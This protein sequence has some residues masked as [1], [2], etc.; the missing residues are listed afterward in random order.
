M[1]LSTPK[2]LHVIMAANH[3]RILV[4]GHN[5]CPLQAMSIAFNYHTIDIE[6]TATSLKVR[7]VAPV[8]RNDKYLIK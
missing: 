6:E 5:S 2:A 1:E 3:K 8:I 4:D 7:G